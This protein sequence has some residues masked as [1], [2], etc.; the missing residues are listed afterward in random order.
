M[1]NDVIDYINRDIVNVKTELQTIS[2]LVR[3]G[4]GQPSLMQ[5]VSTLQND[6][7]HLEGEINDRF[8]EIQ[9]SIESIRN[10]YGDKQKMSWQFKTMMAVALLSSVTSLTIHFSTPPALSENKATDK[11]LQQ[12]VDKLDKLERTPSSKK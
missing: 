2:K 6:I 5:Q 1:G 12:V 9:K 7:T 11:L 3:D 4:N 10:V 8:N